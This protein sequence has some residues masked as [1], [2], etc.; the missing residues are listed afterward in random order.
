M[1]VHSAARKLIRFLKGD[2]GPT[3]VEY[4]FLLTLVLV[5]ALTGITVFGEATGQSLQDSNDELESVL[6]GGGSGG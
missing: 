3:A 6:D 2:D 1:V 4:A 5:V